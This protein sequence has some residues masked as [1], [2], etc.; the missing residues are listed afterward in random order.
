MKPNPMVTVLFVKKLLLGLLAV[1]LLA[2]F[3]PRVFACDVVL[4]CP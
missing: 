1:F 2:I 3:I 4:L